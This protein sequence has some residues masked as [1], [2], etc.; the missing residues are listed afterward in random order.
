MDRIARFIVA[1]SRPI[2]IATAMLSLLAVAMLLLQQ[3]M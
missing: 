3:A 1:K 2:L